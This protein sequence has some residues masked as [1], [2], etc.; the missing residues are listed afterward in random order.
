MP[1]VSFGS[2]RVSVRLLLAPRLPGRCLVG[3]AWEASSGRAGRGEERLS[4]SR[5]LKSRKAW[6][7]VSAGVAAMVAVAVCQV[8]A[9]MEAL[10]S[11]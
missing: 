4:M 3:P 11:R 10:N 5:G 1:S 2:S 6:L 7:V 9:L 8:P